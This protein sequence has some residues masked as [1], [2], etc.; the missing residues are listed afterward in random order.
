[1]SGYLRNH[2]KSVKKRHFGD[3]VRDSF[4]SVIPKKFDYKLDIFECCL[5]QSNK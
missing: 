5:N 2:E 3:G 1:M 4:C